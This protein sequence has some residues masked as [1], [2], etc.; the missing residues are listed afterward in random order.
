MTKKFHDP[1]QIDIQKKE[2]VFDGAENNETLE[3]IDS[4]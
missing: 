4:S 1:P 3:A 2:I